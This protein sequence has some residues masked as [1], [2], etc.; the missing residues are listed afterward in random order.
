[1]ADPWDE[2]G[3]DGA[4]GD[5]V[6]AGLIGKLE[7]VADRLTDADVLRGDEG[8]DLSEDAGSTRV[9]G[10]D[11]HDTPVHDRGYLPE[12]AGGLQLLEDLGEFWLLADGGDGRGDGAAVHVKGPCELGVGQLDGAAVDLGALD[13]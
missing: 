10:D 2:A 13:S 1:M 9:G 12:M 7:V 8:S 5:D 3:W 11:F 6:E 4:F